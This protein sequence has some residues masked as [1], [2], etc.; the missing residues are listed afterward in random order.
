MSKRRYDH[1]QLHNALVPIWQR[2]HLFDTSVQK[3]FYHDW[4]LPEALPLT[5]DRE[6]NEKVSKR[7]ERKPTKQEKR[8]T[9]QRNDVAVLKYA[10]IQTPDPKLIYFLHK[11]RA[12]WQNVHLRASKLPKDCWRMV[13]NVPTVIYKRSN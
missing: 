7:K 1:Y 10:L 12:H 6:R 3:H 9:Q 4:I 13:K 11:N 8:K 2:D 5:G